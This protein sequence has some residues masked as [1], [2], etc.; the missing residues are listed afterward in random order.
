MSSD[1]AK[2]S[3]CDSDSDSKVY[4]GST[5]STVEIE[6]AAIAGITTQ[7]QLSECVDILVARD[8]LCSTCNLESQ[9]RCGSCS[10][11]CGASG[12]V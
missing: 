7:S 1:A 9:E 11:A 10:M 2:S 4:F 5:D 3:Q 6:G 8:P 12:I